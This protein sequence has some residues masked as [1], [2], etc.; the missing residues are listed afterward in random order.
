[1]KR[2]R[3][4]VGEMTKWKA[5]YCAGGHRSVE[6]QTIRTIFTLTIVNE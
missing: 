5:R 2:K 3:N 6:W 4:P 1:M